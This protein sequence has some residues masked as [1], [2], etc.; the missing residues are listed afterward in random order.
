MVPSTVRFLAK[1]GPRVSQ[2][3]STGSPSGQKNWAV[4]SIMSLFDG[5]PPLS[6]HPSNRYQACIENVEYKNEYP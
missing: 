6:G 4:W 1:Q 3:G 5:C 2:T